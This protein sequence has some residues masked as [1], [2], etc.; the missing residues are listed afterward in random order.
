VFSALLGLILFQEFPDIW[1][2]IG[3]LIILTGVLWM[4]RQEAKA[5]D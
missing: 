3:G 2:W 1:V 4:A 5:S